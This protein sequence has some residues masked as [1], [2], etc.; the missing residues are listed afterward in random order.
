MS[1]STFLLSRVTI[2]IYTVYYLYDGVCDSESR[3]QNYK[4]QSSQAPQ[5]TAVAKRRDHRASNCIESRQ[6]GVNA[7]KPDSTG[8]G[9]DGSLWQTPQS[10]CSASS[11]SQPHAA[12]SGHYPA[13]H[14]SPD[15][16]MKI[17]FPRDALAVVTLRVL[18]VLL[19][20][21][22]LPVLPVVLGVILVIL[23]CVI[24]AVNAAPLRERQKRVTT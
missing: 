8:R 11:F 24:P 14:S 4:L 2:Y 6:S 3:I 16:S 23:L 20:L 7:G 18:P 9:T 1:L 22:I 21:P 10:P 15:F 13:C 12:C 5:Q 17:P 19:V